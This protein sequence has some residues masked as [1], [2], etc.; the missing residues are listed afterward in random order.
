MNYFRSQIS[1]N[2][3]SMKAKERSSGISVGLF[4]LQCMIMRIR[5][6]CNFLLYVG[7]PNKDTVSKQIYFLRLLNY[8]GQANLI[9]VLSF[10]W[11]F[12]FE[13]SA[14]PFA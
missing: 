12:L 10:L 6:I 9:S 8:Q 5:K 2:I 11:V 3:G 7:V 4:Q 13:G 1:P 14:C